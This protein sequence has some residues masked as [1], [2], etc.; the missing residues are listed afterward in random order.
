MRREDRFVLSH[1]P[2]AVDLTTIRVDDFS[3]DPF[4][5][6]VWYRRRRGVTVA[7]VGYLHLWTPGHRLE[8]STDDPVTAVEAADDGRYGGTC[9]GR[10]D[11]HGYWGAENPEEAAADL[12]VLRPMLDEFPIIPAGFD[13]WWTWQEAR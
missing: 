13:G 8:W 6:A 10:W 4:I 7:C 1:R 5:N 11:G 3:S 2:Y 12:E 9:T